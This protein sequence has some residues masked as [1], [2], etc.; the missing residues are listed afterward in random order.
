MPN[1]T[2]NRHSTSVLRARCAFWLN[3][4]QNG[5]PEPENFI[6]WFRERIPWLIDELEACKKLTEKIV[7]LEEC[8]RRH[9]AILE[10]LEKASRHELPA[11]PDALHKDNNVDLFASK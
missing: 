5:N 7:K 3:Q 6:I 9:T 2:E 4:I 10:T 1:Q 11:R 8:M